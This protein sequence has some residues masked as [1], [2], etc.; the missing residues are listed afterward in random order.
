MHVNVCRARVKL[1][2]GGYWEKII[3]TF[4]ISFLQPR[5]RNERLHTYLLTSEQGAW[6]RLLLSTDVAR[7]GYKCPMNR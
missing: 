2:R 7:T 1:T 5:L 6:R 4:R 3:L